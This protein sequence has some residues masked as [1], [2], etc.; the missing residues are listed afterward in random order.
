MA[1]NETAMNGFIAE[2]MELQAP[3]NYRVDAEQSGTA[4][5]GNARPDIVVNMPYGLRT[6]VETEY[7]APAVKD[8]TDR[9]GY[10]FNDSTIP[11]KSVIA[12]GIPRELGELGNTERR[13]ALMDDEAQ[14][15]MQVVTGKSEDDPNLSITPDKPVPV[16]L[17]D[18]V[19]YAW[20]AAVP[21]PY[22]EQVMN[23]VTKDMTAAKTALVTKLNACGGEAQKRLTEHYGNHDSANK[24]DSVA[25]NI[26]G[27]LFSMIQL[28]AN[29]K[30]W[31][32]E[33]VDKVL[34]ISAPELWKQ[35]EPYSGIPAKIAHEWRKIETID[36]M[37]LS[38]IAAGMLEDSDVSPRVGDTLRAV[39][40]A[41]SQYIQAGVSATTNVAAE[42]WQSL[43]PDRDQRAAYYTKPATAEMLANMTTRRLASPR[44]AKY[45]EVCAGTGTLSRATE[46]NIRFR[47]YAKSLDKT[48]IHA[49][50]MERSIQL[51]DINPQSVSVATANMASLEPETTFNTSAIFAI[52]ADGGSL[53]FLLPQGVANLE[54]RLVGYSGVQGVMLTAVPRTI[55]ICNNNDPFFRPRGGASSPISKRDMQKYRRAANR[56]VPRVANG[57]SG[58]HTFMH[59]IE[60]TILRSG[61]PHGK[62]LPLSV[63]RT[64]S[65][66]ELR[67]NFENEYC[68]V[69][70]ISTASG[71]GVSMSADTGIQEMLLIGT[72]HTPSS[73]EMQAG[74]RA[75]T[76]VNLTRSFETKLEAKMFA[77]AIHR[78]VSLGKKS[79][80]V[81]VG[82]SV[83]TYYR[84]SSLG[85]GV[86]WSVLGASGDFGV[87]TALL[88][89]GSTWNPATGE[90]TDF[91]LRMTTMN[92]IATRGTGDDLIGKIAG[93]RSPRGAF[94]IHK[95]ANAR[96]RNNPSMW[97]V[98][99]DSQLTITCDPTHY[100]EPRG[101]A[102]AVKRILDTAGH[103]HLSRNLRQSAQKIA[104]CYT[105]TLSI[106]G[107][108]WTTIN[109]EHDVIRAITLF[110]NSTYGLIIRTGYGEAT[111]L[112]RSTMGVTA[113]DGHPIPDFA[114]DTDAAK[115]ARA[116]AAAN[117]ERLRNL[118]FKRISLSAIDANRAEI[119]RVVTQMLGLPCNADT[120]A[121][122][123]VWRKLM[124][125][126]PIVNANNTTTLKTLVEAGIK[127]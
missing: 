88:T 71:D 59:V 103:F 2:A 44:D 90:V 124:C 102:V 1:I 127:V 24:M 108:A 7:G 114:A 77:D 48:S 23:A 29:L 116:I 57:Q 54:E 73:N 45:N 95:D 42:I 122:L 78:E 9:L 63:A 26:V 112:G 113:I 119:D 18:V 58:L 3:P 13:A 110:L 49:D 67:R 98:D 15:L 55:D 35:I 70:A 85:D 68:D 105:P 10:E 60:H 34:D 31:G 93:S 94:I 22:A 101:N 6:I 50:R 87:L 66:L 39:F 33:E 5:R 120:E 21:E 115:Q 109:A 86:P 97:A 81:L 117:F 27:T 125:L 11:M 30:E 37:P 91:G 43:I 52:T 46:E 118:K 72:K 74:D 76:C 80:E 126:Q 82:S 8:A 100:G 106:G 83:G 17:Q 41:V 92:K 14:F 65:N 4:R 61:S 38:T 75:V 89:Q 104:V 107:R 51:T 121:M 53:N 62:V 123:D 79:G 111:D 28:H 69:I 84:I 99:E 47:H 40:T 56:R 96:Y 19:Q 25:G 12:L 20:L 16:S 36:Y 64:V 32:G